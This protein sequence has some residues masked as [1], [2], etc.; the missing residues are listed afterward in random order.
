LAGGAVAVTDGAE[1][2]QAVSELGKSLGLGVRSQ[3]KV[4]RRLWGAVRRIDVVFTDST[5]RKSLGV[6]CKYQKSPGTVEEKLP[7]LIADM[8]SWPISGLL[9][10]AG[11]GFSSNL[12]QYLYSTGRAVDMDDLE[13]WLRL[14]FTLD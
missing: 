1:L 8:A 11:P 2:E 9:V 12:R 14:Y 10:F 13:E 5:S 4:G 3:V 7:G 6:E